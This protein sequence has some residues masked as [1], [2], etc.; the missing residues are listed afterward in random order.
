MG[1]LSECTQ[2]LSQ[3]NC[4]SSECCRSSCH[5][6]QKIRAYDACPTRSSLATDST[7]GHF[8]NSGSAIQVPARHGSTVPTG[9]LPAAVVSRQR[10]SEL[11]GRLAVPRTRR[12]Y[13]DRSFAIQGPQTWN[14]LPAD[15][16]APD[17]SVETFRHKLKTFLF[18]V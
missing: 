18:A 11:S 6:S 15:L 8:Q 1:R 3:H 17:I 9:I 4:K 16:R 13:G 7:V 10:R 5:R 2:K 12:N 14:S